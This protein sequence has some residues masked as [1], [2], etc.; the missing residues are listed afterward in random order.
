MSKDIVGSRQLKE[1]KPLNT[2]IY[3]DPRYKKIKR[4]QLSSDDIASIIKDVNVDY[5]T[6]ADAARH[7][8]VSV[9]LVR[10]VMS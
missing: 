9:T 7:N 5:L 4:S 8:C 3:V 6:Y 10:N 1:E 2:S